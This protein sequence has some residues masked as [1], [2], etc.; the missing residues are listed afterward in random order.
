MKHPDARRRLFGGLGLFFALMLLFSGK[1]IRLQVV[2]GAAYYDQ[3]QRRIARVETVEAARGEIYDRNGRAIVTNQVAFSLSLSVSE[4]GDGRDETLLALLGLLNTAQISWTDELPISA[5]APFSYDDK[6]S[7]VQ[8]KRFESYLELVGLEQPAT[9]DALLDDLAA[10]Y[11][12]RPALP[13]ATKRQLVAVLYAC[14]LRTREV[15][16]TPYLLAEGLD[17]DFVARLT[18]QDFDGVSVAPVSIRRYET[19]AAAHILGRVGLMDEA[20]W[21]SYEPLGYDM[22]AQVGKDGV[23]LAFEEFLHPQR[24]QETTEADAEGRI[25]GTSYTRT[26]QPGSSVMLTLDLALQEKT[27]QV[28]AELVPTLPG[29]EGAAVAILDVSDGGVLT[30]ASYPSYDL[31]SFSQQYETLAADPLEPLFN[32]ALQGT[33]APGSTF[34]MVPAIAALEQ[35]IITPET[36]ILDTGI[37]R[38]YSSPQPRCWLYRQQHRTHGAETVS[39]AITDSC[40]VFFYDV[41]RRLGI[42]T[43]EDYARRFG[44]G[45]KSGIELGG[46]SAGVVASAYYTESLG[47]T[48]YE[49]NTLS[50]AIGQENNRFTPLQLAS[51]VATLAGGGRRMQVHLLSEVKSFDRTE[52][53]QQYAPQI[54]DEIPMT[55]AHLDAVKSGMLGVTTEG[56]VAAYFRDL[57][58]TVGAKT[59]SVQVAGSDASNA[60][61]VAFAPYENPEIALAIVVE[62]GGS[63]SELGAIAAELL[64]FYFE[65]EVTVGP[66]QL[67][68][69]AE[70][71][72]QNGE[73]SP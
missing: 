33:Y 26:P 53:L 27:E 4:M 61:F 48:W 47:Q 14:D 28:L 56:S 30:L 55:Q 51:Y 10:L 43:L 34:K 18:E 12:L 1:L 57:P 35:G 49:G 40:N 58:V 15:T 17:N 3:S 71:S 11:D 45:E 44:L 39:E 37:Y 67:P 46:E 21:K 13:Q 50:A 72:L 8:L 73:N 69:D 20:Q 19:T 60:V 62:K 5:E 42:A 31:A 25:T 41:G 68:P 54:L 59:G 32:R 16:W 63:G 29:A 7:A 66:V 22:D 70:S 65:D 24:G 64:G 2:Q 9:A 23:E 38:Y 36:R 6:A 52:S